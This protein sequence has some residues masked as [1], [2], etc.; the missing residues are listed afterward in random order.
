MSS[1][2]MRE[3]SVSSLE[4]PMAGSSAGEH[5]HPTERRAAGVTGQIDPKSSK[6][7]TYE[8]PFAAEMAEMES[9]QS[10][11]VDLASMIEG[12]IIPRL[13]FAHGRD[14]SRQAKAARAGY[15]PD[16]ADIER[17]T[18]HILRDDDQ[19]LQDYADDLLARG[20]PIDHLF[21]HLL[22]PVARRLGEMWSADTC[23]FTEVT[24]GLLRLQQLLRR[25]APSFYRQELIPADD[26]SILLTA[27]PGEQ[28]TFGL[29]MLAEFF[30]RAGWS[31]DQEPHESVS[32][33]LGCVR[34]HWYTVVGLSLSSE[35]RTNEIA[36][37][38]MALREQAQ[39]PEMGVM[40][41]GSIF[42]DRP[43]LVDFVGADMGGRDAAGAVTDA[44][45]YRTAVRNPME[46]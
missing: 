20:T 13:M 30:R 38:V 34:N 3:T 19:V 42:T 23:S 33:L 6:G 29:L 18:Q 39:N 26:R 21:L 44:E 35:R 16:A 5:L 24:I 25:Y 7:R 31:V 27:L 37:L 15:E 9:P 28:H 40:V 32:S 41:G 43:E 22:A 36:E 11:L 2:S 8:S 14:S 12:E 46:D 4:G 1:A 45:S 17:F 10:R